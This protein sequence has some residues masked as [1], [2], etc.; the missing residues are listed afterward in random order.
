MTAQHGCKR[1]YE[2]TLVPRAIAE[3]FREA[4]ELVQYHAARTECV[5]RMSAPE[6]GGGDVLLTGT[7]A[8]P[9]HMALSRR[10]TGCPLARAWRRPGVS[11][12]AGLRSAS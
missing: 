5:G 11:A 3:P 2:Q 4:G 8:R 12:R 6:A 7:P 9:P 10:L 1:E